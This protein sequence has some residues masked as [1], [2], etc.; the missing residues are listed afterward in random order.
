M[1]LLLDFHFP[2][3]PL[4]VLEKSALNRTLNKGHFITVSMEDVAAA[5]VSSEEPLPVEILREPRRFSVDLSLR[6]RTLVICRNLVRASAS[7]IRE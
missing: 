3:K 1:Q 5:E 4:A 7:T 2:F 6:Y